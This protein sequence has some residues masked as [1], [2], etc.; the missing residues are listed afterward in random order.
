LFSLVEDVEVAD[1]DIDELPR[2]VFRLG[3][4]VEDCRKKISVWQA[5][6]SKM[7]RAKS[8]EFTNQ[9][10]RSITRGFTSVQ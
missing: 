6:K 3:I 9:C 8:V 10:V 7:A 2:V 4:H 5:P 1:F